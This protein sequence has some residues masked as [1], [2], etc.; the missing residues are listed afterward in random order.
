MSSGA[1]IGLITKYIPKLIFSFFFPFIFKIVNLGQSGTPA[2][3]MVLVRDNKE[4]WVGCGNKIVIV[5]TNTLILLDEIVVYQSHRTHVRIMV[6]DGER[7]WSGD[8]RSTKILQW[9]VNNRQLTHLFECDVDNPVGKVLCSEIKEPRRSSDKEASMGRRRRRRVSDPADSLDQPSYTEAMLREAMTDLWNKDEQESDSHSRKDSHFRDS[10]KHLDDVLD[11][12]VRT[13]SYPVPIPGSELLSSEVSVNIPSN[14]TDSRASADSGVSS[15]LSANITTNTATSSTSDAAWTKVDTQD[16]NIVATE[17]SEN[18]IETDVEIPM[19]NTQ[20]VSKNSREERKSD[21]EA[22]SRDESRKAFIEAKKKNA[23]SEEAA[24]HHC[25]SM[26]ALQNRFRSSFRAPSL[27]SSQRRKSQ[28]RKTNEDDNESSA[29]SITKP[30]ARRPRLRILPGSINRVTSLLIVNGTLWI[31]RGVGDVL[32][33]NVNSANNDLP[34]GHV[35][36]QLVADNLLGYENGQV[37][38]IVNSGTNKVVCLRRLELAR[39]SVTEEERCT[40]RYQLVVWEAWGD[41][42]FK[43]FKDRLDHFNS[44]VN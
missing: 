39:G 8:R 35:F 36:A 9:D 23:P 28:R 34:H 19:N 42:Q 15:F 11:S 20:Y 32:T 31:G 3:S 1:A 26:D 38:E 40:E 17:T 16:D 5:D 12:T 21:V 33:V 44:L 13:V 37:D 30:W 41:T 29:G 6:T 4:L 22:L 25:L 27:M 43:K 14:D 7:V 18:V 2:K 10:E 24:T